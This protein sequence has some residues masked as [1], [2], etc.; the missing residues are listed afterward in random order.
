MGIGKRKDH[1]FTRRRRTSV[2]Q[3][4][5][6]SATAAH[7]L[8]T[9]ASSMRKSPISN[10]AFQ[11]LKASSR[12][13]FDLVS[14]KNTSS[15]TQPPVNRTPTE[16]QTVGS[17]SPL[18]ISMLLLLTSFPGFVVF[19]VNYVPAQKRRNNERL[20]NLHKILLS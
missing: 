8:A 11:N 5:M 18:T 12:S 1:I 7:T 16:E 6:N 19:L 10:T 20:K 13:I 14:R 17:S 9:K 15:S 4:S 2:S 3:D